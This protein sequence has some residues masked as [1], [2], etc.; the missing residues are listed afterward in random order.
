MISAQEDSTVNITCKANGNPMPEI[1]WKEKGTGRLIST[2][3]VLSLPNIS[4]DQAGSY[5]CQASNIIG[6]SQAIETVIDIKCECY[7]KL[8]RH[9]KCFV[10]RWS[11]CARPGA[12]RYC[13]EE[14]Q[15]RC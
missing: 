10:P 5:I 9:T 15:V 1:L 6:T 8:E 4:K 14:I 11:H 12:R 13:G 7:H 2:N 3:G